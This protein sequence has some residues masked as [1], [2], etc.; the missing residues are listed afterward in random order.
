MDIRYYLSV[1]PLEALIASQLSPQDFGRYMATGKKNGSYERI[2]FIELEG[3][4]GSHFD[5]EYAKERCVPHEDGRPKNSVWMAVYRA[6]EHVELDKLRS[7]YLTTPDGR[8]LEIPRSEYHVPNNDKDYF[9]YQEI[10][11]ITPLVVSRLDPAEFGKFMTDTANKV[12]VPKVV[13]SDLKTIDFDNPE[14]TGNIGDA[15]DKNIEHL[16]E[17]ITDVR[18]QNDKPNK[19]VERSVRSFAY[20]I[21]NRGVYVAEGSNIVE[22]PMPSV[23]ELRRNHYNWARSAM[24]L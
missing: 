20:Q 2:M 15:Y 9:V 5:W 18:N 17:C 24:V 6:L 19:N 11:P 10:A 21:I 13:F 14:N 3:E 12:S 16:R 8:T 1:N 7:L 22:Y 23:E 4:F